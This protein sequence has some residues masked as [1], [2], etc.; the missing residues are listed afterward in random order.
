M[1]ET[2]M[3][4]CAS[5]LNQN[6]VFNGGLDF[7]IGQAGLYLEISLFTYNSYATLMFCKVPTYSDLYRHGTGTDSF[8]VEE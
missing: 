8:K 1:L 2:L 4:A 7:L 3:L 5:Q 6:K